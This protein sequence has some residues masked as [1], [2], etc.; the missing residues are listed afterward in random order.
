MSYFSF[1]VCS[2]FWRLEPWRGQRGRWWLNRLL[3]LVCPVVFIFTVQ[4]TLC[5][6]VHPMLKVEVSQQ[7]HCWPE[8]LRSVFMSGETWCP[9][10]SVCYKTRHMHLKLFSKSTIVRFTVGFESLGPMRRVVM[11]WSSGLA[12]WTSLTWFRWLRRALRSVLGRGA[13]TARR[14]C[15]TD[16]TFLMTQH[17]EMVCHPKEGRTKARRR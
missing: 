3:T 4:P 15:W 1:S 2:L 10:V 11:G 14:P 13:V 16:P 7:H 12:A 5:P 6:E 9:A 17:P 8:Q